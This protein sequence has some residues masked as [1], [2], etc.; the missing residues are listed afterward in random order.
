MY[1]GT[2]NGLDVYDGYEFNNYHMN[3]FDDNS[4]FGN[5][6][7]SISEDKKLAFKKSDYIVVATP[8]NYDDKTNFF[9]TSLEFKFLYSIFVRYYLFNSKKKFLIQNLTVLRI[10]YINLF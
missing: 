9:D 10:S 2:E 1:L 7:S 6:V 8:T 5:K 4:I 3:S